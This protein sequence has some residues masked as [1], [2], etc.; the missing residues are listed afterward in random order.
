VQV[1][2]ELPVAI[3]VSVKEVRRPR[4]GRRRVS[5]P[6]LLPVA[7]LPLGLPLIALPFQSGWVGALVLGLVGVVLVGLNVALLCV[8]NFP[9]VGRVGG[10]LAIAAAGY[11]LTTAILLGAAAASRP[12]LIPDENWKEFKSPDGRCRMQ[13]PGT[14]R[15]RQ[16][17]LAPLEQNVDQHEVSLDA[18]RTVFSFA[19]FDIPDKFKHVALEDR[20]RG[21]RDG[22]MNVEPGVRLVSERRIDLAGQHPGTEF[23]LDARSKGRAHVRMYVVG[24]RIYLLAVFGHVHTTDA[25]R[26]LDSFQ[27]ADP[28]RAAQADAKA[29]PAEQAKQPD[30]LRAKLLQPA[31]PP[32]GRSPI[33]PD[34]RKPIPPEELPPPPDVA[35]RIPDAK[36][37]PGLIG[38]W[39]FNEGR[40][41]VVTD[42]SLQ[43]NPGTVRG[44]WWINGVK[45]RA[46]LLDGK[47][48]HFDFGS[49]ERFHY[50]AGSGFT[51]AGWFY[52]RRDLGT[53]LSQ[54][55]YHSE[56]PAVEVSIER[57]NLWGGVRCDN[58]PASL[59]RI[60][61]NAVPLDRWQH[62][63]LCREPDGTVELFLNGVSQGRLR[64]DGSDGAITTNMRT[65]GYERFMDLKKGTAPIRYLHGGVDEFCI[66]ERAL[67][68]TEVA[69][70]AGVKR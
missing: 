22:M 56:L 15:L 42:S 39:R 64:K 69:Q 66:F 7:L 60:K 40:G 38:Y 17:F 31:P 28:V 43:G 51:V 62:F 49:S 1:P 67:T 57:G 8:K 55:N 16:E 14:P 54:R 46:L 20:F 13:M 26:F 34:T 19:G 37:F 29:G 12:N 21:A 10:S 6:V 27:L 9:T 32:G 63:A 59:V 4:P 24:R 52:T 30:P 25:L 23:I 18:G 45:G 5:V 3:P 50:A 61:G 41:V 68:A 35:D 70:L 11:V 65:L 2:E 47:G 53:L 44:G 48:D 36:Q 58:A 33:D